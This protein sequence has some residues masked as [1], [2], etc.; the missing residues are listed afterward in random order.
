MR[1]S[2]A[3]LLAGMCVAFTTPAIAQTTTSYTVTV[4][5]TP[6]VSAVNLSSSTITTLGPTN[7]GTAVGSVSV[8]MNPPG[9]SYSG[10]I[11]LGGTDG[12]KFALTNGG[13]LPCNLTI[14]SA[15][16]AA[17]TYQISLTAP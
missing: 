15:N 6:V 16:L 13:R 12:T 17:G 1:Q 11:S 7:A 2:L 10:T 14:G 9:G 4:V 5:V 3:G 8:T